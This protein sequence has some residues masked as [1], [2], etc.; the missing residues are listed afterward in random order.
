MLVL[1]PLKA[2]LPY[3]YTLNEENGLP[4]NEVYQVIQDEKGFMWIAC[5]AGLFRYDGVR[6]KKYSCKAENGR[7]ISELK[8][9]FRKRL[10]CQN[11]SGQLFYVLG[12]SLV[13][14]KDFSSILSTYP[15]YTIDKR[16][17]VWVTS[18]NKLLT[19]DSL[20]QQ[21]DLIED[22]ELLRQYSWFDIEF[23]AKNELLATSQNNG[24][25]K[26]YEMQDG[27][28]RIKWLKKD[29][30]PFTQPFIENKNNQQF[31]I[32]ESGVKKNYSLYQVQDTLITRLIEHS[33]YPFTLYKIALNPA[34]HFWIS[35]SEGVFRL[36][37]AHKKI[38]TSV[39]LLKHDKISSLYE[40]R[41]GCIWLTSLENGIHVIPNPQLTVINKKN[42]RISDPL[43]TSINPGPSE[44]IIFGTYNGLIYTL[45]NNQLTS[46]Q[47][48]NGPELRAVKN[49]QPYKNGYLISSGRFSY[50]ANGSEKILALKNLRDFCIIGDTLFIVATN[51]IA[52]IPSIRQLIED[53]KNA[54][55]MQMLSGGGRSL[56]A[57][58]KNGVVYFGTNNG[59]IKY[60]DG[61]FDSVKFQGK[62]VNVSKIIYGGE[63]IWIGTFNQGVL[64]IQNG[65]FNAELAINKVIKGSTIKALAFSQ[66]NLLVATDVCLHVINPIT[67]SCNYIDNTDGLTTKEIN[68]ILVN[69][70]MVYLATNKGLISF[71]ESGQ[72]FNSTRPNI[73]ITRVVVN[74][75]E[76]EKINEIS[77]PYGKNNIR[78]LF[79]NACIRARGKHHYSYRLQG[80]DTNW[81]ELGA[82]HT[83]VNFT[84]LSSGT[85]TFELKALNEDHLASEKTES[86]IIYVQ[87]P[88]WQQWWFYLLTTL[89]GALIVSIIAWRVISNNNQRAEDRNQLIS[90]QLAA[91]RAQMNPHFL[92]NTLN[93]IQDLILNDEIK[94]TNYYLSRFSSLMRRILEF[95]QK[96]YVTIEEECEMLQGYLELEKLRFGKDFSFHIHHTDAFEVL[97]TEIPSLIVQPFVENAIKHG[98]LHK[99]GEKKLMVSFTNKDKNTIVTIEDNGIGRQ[100]A[101][102]IQKRSTLQHQSFA[103]SAVN[104]RL[105][106]IN[107]TSAQ[108]ID[109]KIIDL[110]D[111][112][113]PLGTR[114][115]III[116]II[117]YG[118]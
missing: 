21:L 88:F 105:N 22:P 36:D 63:K 13:L 38:D 44:S 26:L 7:S 64:S 20:G 78:I 74:D 104:N 70:G 52:V 99:K 54:P 108:K 89:T 45:K 37:V 107:R 103:S 23:G 51:K 73:T 69:H 85:Y 1:T 75:V 112:T 48:T 47:R 30:N 90:S 114:V 27:K 92:Y 95:S 94:K 43:I 96:D 67:L 24:I 60:A 91:I 18:E 10:W 5:D 106:L 61:K 6:I 57:D 80:V 42:N 3:Y 113:G 111:E 50:Y 34:P 71:P 8:F 93:S 29:L 49:I 17:R 41:E 72:T 53:N 97:R 100:R 4:S 83:E 2:Q 56:A 98:L 62:R 82:E 118:S 76:Q 9:D 11:F 68:G 55:K 110:S 102:E 87:K 46:I 77:A 39:T 28:Y 19:F 115:E 117:N 15:Q 31:I 25:A 86:I 109:L 79:E 65:V 14:F 40:D 84:S 16:G 101:G 66:E 35:T 58:F 81:I 59:L 116:P 33:V 32:F 12:D